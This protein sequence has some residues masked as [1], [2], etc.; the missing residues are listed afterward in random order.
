[1]K[2]LPK[3]IT[4]MQM[5]DLYA[6]QLSTKTVVEAIK[7]F[8]EDCN[9]SIQKRII[10]DKVKQLFFKRFGLPTGYEITPETKIE[11]YK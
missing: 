4:K 11:E 8:Q 7:N 5:V 3:K 1:M 10:P 2:P 9:F 6:N